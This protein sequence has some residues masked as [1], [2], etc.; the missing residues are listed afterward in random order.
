MNFNHFIQA[1][2]W[3]STPWRQSLTWEKNLVR[4]FAICYAPGSASIVMLHR[5]PH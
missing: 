3:L 5:L 1:S 2:Q 4:A